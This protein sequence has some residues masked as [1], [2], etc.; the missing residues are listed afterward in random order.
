[1]NTMYTGTSRWQ[2]LANAFVNAT[3]GTEFTYEALTGMLGVAEDQRQVISATLGKTRTMM[4]EDG[5]GLELETLRNVGYRV[6]S[7]TEPTG[8]KPVKTEPKA[9][10]KRGRKAIDKAAREAVAKQQET[11]EPAPFNASAVETGL[12]TLFDVIRV[13]IAL[14]E[15]M[16]NKITAL[17]AE[18]A[19][20]HAALE[21]TR[22]QTHVMRVFEDFAGLAAA[23]A[24]VAV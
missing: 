8:E 11:A 14:S 13:Q 17:E 12:R 24:E 16:K 20:L 1:M 10:K 22:N 3:P 7:V 15:E 18:T 2:V 4:E 21:T 5:W 19:A 6:V 9:G 23:E